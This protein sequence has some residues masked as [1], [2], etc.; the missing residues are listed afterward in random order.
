MLKIFNPDAFATT[1]LYLNPFKWAVATNIFQT[2]EIAQCIA[3]NFP[4]RLLRFQQ[5][6]SMWT[7]T[8]GC[9]QKLLLKIVDVLR[10]SKNCQS[11]G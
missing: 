3:N 1:Q 4:Y 2:Y 11:H 5:K 9:S 10:L 7:K 6:K 8:I